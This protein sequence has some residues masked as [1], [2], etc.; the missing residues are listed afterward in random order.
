MKN[1]RN[2]LITNGCL[3]LLYFFT[4]LVSFLSYAVSF[5]LF[6]NVCFII[7]SILFITYV[8]YHI[9][10]AGQ[11]HYLMCI[12]VMIFLFM[13][14]R[15]LKYGAFRNVDVMAPHLWYAYYVPILFIP[16]FLFYLALKLGKERDKKDNVIL[17]STG[18]VTS[19]LAVL[20]MTN[21]MHQTAF[22]FR[23]NFENWDGD[24]SHSILYVIVVAWVAALLVASFAVLIKKCR[25]S[26]GKKYFWIA[27]LPII[28]GVVWL[29]M[30]ILDVLPMVNGRNVGNEFPETFCFMIVGFILSCVQIGLIPSNDHYAL[31]LKQTSIPAHISDYNGNIVYKS[32][33]SVKMPENPMP[34]TD[35]SVT[36]GDSV[37]RTV[38]I[39]GGTVTWCEDISELNRLNETLS[40]I[41][42]KL[43]EENELQQRRN[44]LKEENLS[45][46][47]KNKLYDTIA[48]AVRTQSEEIA[49]LAEEAAKKPALFSHN[50]AHACFLNCF[51]KRY[52][53]LSLITKENEN[54]AVA[55]LELAVAESLRY[56]KNM[57]IITVVV[58]FS[59]T[60]TTA[61]GL[62]CAYKT[63]ENVLEENLTQLRG[64]Q[65]IFY[66]TGNIV[67]RFAM[68]GVAFAR[69]EKLDGAH[70]GGIVFAAS[71]DED[72]SYLDI[73][74]EEAT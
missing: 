47:E 46:D 63:I 15:A 41:H 21:D 13:M 40:E 26:V 8:G 33:S 3:L 6:T 54:I 34:S 14:L 49:R 44:R 66:Q 1:I 16:Y 62:I 52:A 11:K 12:A 57:G 73:I 48:R 4:A 50:M 5:S 43:T 9:G 32:I 36:V 19:V 70:E 39:P 64:V 18:I 45:L 2:V 30:D 61:K 67:C 27:F 58:G 51:I 28:F 10:N 74:L 60:K 37:V 72:I 56:L 65:A 23:P 55:E 71:G 68:E 20:V 35:S 31:L 38:S 53:N 22:A 29:G 25:I 7:L 69:I 59:E 17:W 42:E 24:Y